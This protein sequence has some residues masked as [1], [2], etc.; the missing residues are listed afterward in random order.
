M[1][2]IKRNLV[3]VIGAAIALLLM[4][5]AGFYTW[6]GYNHHSVADEELVAKYTELKRLTELN[7]SPGSGKVDNIKAAREQEQTVRRIFAQAQRQF[8]PIPAIPEGGTN[9][10]AEA[11]ANSLSRII[12][13]LQ[14]EASN[15][16]VILTPKYAFSFQQQ[17]SLMKFAPGSVLPLSVQLG[18]V[19][20]L[21]DVLI[22]AKVNYL[23]SIQRERVSTDDNLGP[24]TDY[25]DFKSQTNDLAVITPYQFTFRCFTPELAQVLCGFAS[26]PH[27]LIVKSFN[28]ELAPIT[29]VE[30]TQAPLVYYQPTSTAEAPRR[31]PLA[32]RYGMAGRYG[33]GG[34]AGGMGGPG[35]RDGYMRPPPTYAPPPV[36][37][38]GVAAPPP[39]V[40]RLV[41][42]EKQLKVTM[43]VE[44]VKLQPTK[45]SA[46]GTE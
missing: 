12:T 19:K 2:W 27:G 32:E 15:V 43:L 5:G 31:D 23:D 33:M 36:A 25:L 1:D 21:A 39:T 46:R 18:E 8:E 42:N 16:S 29:A 30:T 34:R 9:V 38:P 24:Q 4:V 44:V 10:T 14:R 17:S 26:S 13:T 41:L 35:G 45:K 22:A 37:A 40:P 28:V 3:F 11:F 6:T 7:P 20:V